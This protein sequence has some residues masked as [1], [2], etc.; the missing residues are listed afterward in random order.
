MLCVLND[1]TLNTEQQLSSLLDTGQLDTE[2]PGKEDPTQ[3]GSSPP[4]FAPSTLNLLTQC[5]NSTKSEFQSANRREQS[6]WF[7]ISPSSGQSS[8]QKLESPPN[9]C[10]DLIFSFLKSCSC[11]VDVAGLSE[12]LAGPLDNSLPPHQPVLAANL[13]SL[14]IA[15]HAATVPPCHTAAPT[16]SPGRG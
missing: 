7:S 2:P 13:A 16:G 1:W 8:L 14:C 9:K 4:P 6:C 12:S 10:Y 3:L 15:P 5:G 11:S